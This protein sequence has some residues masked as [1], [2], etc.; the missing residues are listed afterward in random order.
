VG[1]HA[2]PC[3]PNSD[4]VLAESTVMWRRRNA[5]IGVNVSA[6]H[7]SSDGGLVSILL[8]RDE[9]DVSNC[10]VEFCDTQQDQNS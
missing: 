7:A 2:I 8:P 4:F 9:I 6:L 10:V 1:V 3:L 5:I